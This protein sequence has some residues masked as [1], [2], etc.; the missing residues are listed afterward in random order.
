MKYEKRQFVVLPNC[1]LPF[2][3]KCIIPKV[4]D[5]VF[6]LFSQR[7]KIAENNKKVQRMT[8]NSKGLFSHR[9]RKKKISNLLL[10]VSC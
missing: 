9:F 4:A 10:C 1:R 8:L 3:G 7:G 5:F 2:L 6:A